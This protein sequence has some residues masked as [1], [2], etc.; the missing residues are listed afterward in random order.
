MLNLVLD[1]SDIIISPLL[2]ACFDGLVLFD[3]AAGLFWIMSVLLFWIV[4]SF[5]LVC[6]PVGWFVVIWHCCVLHILIVG[7]I[8]EGRR[9]GMG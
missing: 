9:W 7:F 6:C 2:P 8:N 5:K 4:L 1:V 3:T